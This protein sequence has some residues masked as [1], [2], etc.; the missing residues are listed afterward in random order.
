MKKTLRILALLLTAAL[1]LGMFASCGG[2]GVEDPIEAA[3]LP[4]DRT[5]PDPNGVLA[6]EGAKIALLLC[7]AGMRSASAR[8]L[9]TV[10]ETFAKEN[11]IAESRLDWYMLPT[12]ADIEKQLDEILAKGY[13][14]VVN[15]NGLLND[16]IKSRAKDFPDVRFVA[17]EGWFAPKG[18]LLDPAE[19]ANL[20]QGT[21]RAEESAFI[22][23]YLLAGATKTAKIGLLNGT[24]NP[25]GFQMEAGFRAGV[26]YAEQTLQK[27]VEI[28]TE[29]VGNGFDRTGGK[30]GAAALYNSGCDILYL[31]AGGETD[32][33]ALETAAERGKPVVTAGHTS[34]LA[35]GS[36]VGEVLKS[37]DPVIKGIFEALLQGEQVQG[38]QNHGLTD[39]TTG[40]KPTALSEEFFGK[41]LLLKLDDVVKEIKS[42]AIAIPQDLTEAG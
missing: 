17:L 14:V 38:V 22:A 19:Y 21:V 29:Y 42:G 40:F 27:T 13:R 32:W 4:S 41:D 37:K 7:S 15:N 20:T 10:T 8:A 1:C 12:P 6:D 33:G 2:P 23:G 36:V 18:T 39:G 31:C 16:Y 35:P 25:P 34:Y 9:W 26:A 3:D 30:N 5:P 11:G 28:K 24:P